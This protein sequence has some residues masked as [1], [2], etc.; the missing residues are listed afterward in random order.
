MSFLDHIKR[1]NNANLGEFEPWFIGAERA[2]FIHRDFAPVVVSRPDLFARCDKAWHLDPALDTAD[3][4]TAAMRGFLLELREEGHFKGLWR[5]EAYPVTWE[6]TQAPL[7]TMERA[8]VPCSACAPSGRTLRA[9]F[10]DV[11][12]CISGFP[13]APMTSP[14]SPESS[15]TRWP[16]ANRRASACMTI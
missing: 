2:G 8:T 11:T 1:C 9:T 6:F 7:M 4:R 3:K 5:E 12:D 16:A 10:G 14:P 13:A 15:T